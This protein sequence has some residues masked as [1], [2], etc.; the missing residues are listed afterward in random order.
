MSEVG[1]KPGTS[2]LQLLEMC[3]LELRGQGWGVLVQDSP[4][5][6]S[7]LEGPVL[8][9]R[10]PSSGHRPGGDARR[11]AGLVVR[12]MSAHCGLGKAGGRALA[13]PGMEQPSGPRRLLAAGSGL[14]RGAQTPPGHTLE[15]GS[16]A[17]LPARHTE[18]LW[19]GSSTFRQRLLLGD[20]HAEAGAASRPVLRPCW[21]APA[22]CVLG[23][24]PGGVRN[25]GWVAGSDVADPGLHRGDG[26][27]ARVPVQGPLAPDIARL[28]H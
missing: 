11:P 4:A 27:G 5:G 23:S 2:P 24:L 21:A 18:Q 14:S 12:G 17:R 6:A 28:P 19:G 3:G 1:K 22:L 8:M 20:G 9:P 7:A 26:S 25:C 10:F 15:P 13:L 16:R